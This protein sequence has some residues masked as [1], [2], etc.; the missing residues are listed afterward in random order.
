MNVQKLNRQLHKIRLANANKI[1]RLFIIQIKSKKYIHTNPL[2][3][4][5]FFPLLP[6]NVSLC[7]LAFFLSRWF[8]LQRLPAS[9]NFSPFYIN[10]NNSKRPF[11]P[12]P[13][14][15]PFT[16]L[17]FRLFSPIGDKILCMYTAIGDA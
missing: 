9:V 13:N 6:S 11:S 12:P 8:P 4:S 2:A 10:N 1:M 5:D 17:L 15:N 3:A 7:L 14:S 16:P